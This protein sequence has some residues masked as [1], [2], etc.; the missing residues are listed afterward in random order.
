[1]KKQKL[2]RTYVEGRESMD[3]P[4]A[5][6]KEESQKENFSLF[7]GGTVGVGKA[8]VEKNSSSSIYSGYGPNTTKK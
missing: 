4:Y 6:W 5:F 1:M 3:D 8:N 7:G 2:V